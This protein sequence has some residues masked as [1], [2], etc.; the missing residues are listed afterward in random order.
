MREDISISGMKFRD[1]A[2][3]TTLLPAV[4]RAASRSHHGAATNAERRCGANSCR[5]LSL[6]RVRGGADYIEGEFQ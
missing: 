2:G 6:G 5:R 3:A 4:N 1:Q